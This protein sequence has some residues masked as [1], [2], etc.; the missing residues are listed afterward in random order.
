MSFRHDPNA[1][2]NFGLAGTHNY[3]GDTQEN[4]QG[5]AGSAGTGTG[6]GTTVGG[7]SLGQDPRLNTGDLYDQGR[8]AEERMKQENFKELFPTPEFKPN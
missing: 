4:I 1:S 8:R 2:G 6:T 5:G 3:K 7:I